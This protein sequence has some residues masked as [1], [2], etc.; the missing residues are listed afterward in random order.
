MSAHDVIF[1]TNSL[2]EHFTLLSSTHERNGNI[3]EIG[4]VVPGTTISSLELMSP[5]KPIEFSETI[6]LTFTEMN[7]QVTRSVSI[8]VS[9]GPQ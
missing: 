3:I 1:Q 9:G 5:S 4:T 6:G 2:F 8:S 7:E